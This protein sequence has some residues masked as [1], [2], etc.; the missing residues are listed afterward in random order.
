MRPS[1]LGRAL[2]GQQ[3][4]DVLLEEFVGGGGMGAVFRGR[5]LALDRIVAVKVLALN[6]QADAENTRRFE[7]EGR[8]AARLDHPN[9]ARVHYV[10]L[11]RGLRYIVFEF[12]DG[13][14]ARDLVKEHGPLS[15]AHAVSFGLQISDALVHAWQRE[16]VHRDIK[17]SN[18]L[19]TP[20]GQAKLVDMGL[21]R[22]QNQEQDQKANDL[23]ASG[24]TL[25]TFDYL[26]PEQAMDPRNA[27]ARS[28]IYSLGCTLYFMLTGR[29]PFPDGTA[30]QKMMKHQGDEPESVRAF[31]ADIPRALA[32][33][34]GKMLAKKPEDRY[35]D[36]VELESAL[37]VIARQLNIPQVMPGA[38][39]MTFGTPATP[40]ASFNPSVI[41]LVATAVLVVVGA[42]LPNWWGIESTSNR[43]EQI[44]IAE[45]AT[46]QPIDEDKLEDRGG[47][48]P[49]SDDANFSEIPAVLEI[50]TPASGPDD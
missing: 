28:D 30:M 9:I 44:P 17:P 5:D 11:D 15:I 24:T 50:E 23:T 29:P 46:I 3:I 1:D 6:E 8:S 33:V 25:G 10:G 43:F 4:N 49:S 13:A 34:I 40:A 7:V 31:R 16:V 20:D 42:L 37:T 21:A 12:I 19:I 26:A 18:I 36:P 38:G 48:F 39:L 27:D 47:D 32:V 45:E 22:L 2:V 14:N 35:Q 41:W